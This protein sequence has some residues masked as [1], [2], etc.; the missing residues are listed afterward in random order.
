MP[1]QTFKPIK[2]NDIVLHNGQKHLVVGVHLDDNKIHLNLQPLDNSIKTVLL[3]E[4]QL[5]E[6]NYRPP[7]KSRFGLKINKSGREAWDYGINKSK[8]QNLKTRI[9]YNEEEL[10]GR[11]KD[12][13]LE[14]IK[15]SGKKSIDQ[16]MVDRVVQRLSATQAYLVT[17][18]VKSKSVKSTESFIEWRQIAL[19]ALKMANMYNQNVN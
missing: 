18:S 14:E 17:Q 4:V 10:V 11:I 19:V 16:S 15:S 8:S 13:L 7:V 12:L 5:L 6:E 1:E 3:G 2:T 9:P